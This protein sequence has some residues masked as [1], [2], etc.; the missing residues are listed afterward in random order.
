[1]GGFILI[2]IIKELEKSKKKFEATIPYKH[3]NM[4]RVKLG[5]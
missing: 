3:R 4:K 5:K 2:I 1:M